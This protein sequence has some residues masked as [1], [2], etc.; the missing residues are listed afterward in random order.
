MPDPTPDDLIVQL[1]TLAARWADYD[2]VIAPYLAHIRT[3]EIAM[4]DATAA[5]TFEIDTLK[6]HVTPLLVAHGQSLKLD[7]VSALVS[8]RRSWDTEGLL[9]FAQEVP[10]VLQFLRET[11]SVS[12]RHTRTARGARA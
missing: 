1:E 6:A 2:A 11:T 12:F 3:L 10:S 9:A 5:L 7:G 4:A 8:L